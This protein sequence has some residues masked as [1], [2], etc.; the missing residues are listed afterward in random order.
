MNKKIFKVALLT[1]MIALLSASLVACGLFDAQKVITSADVDVVSGLDKVEDGVYKAQLGVETVLAVNWHNNRVS[2]A[3]VEWHV[4]SEGK[5]NKIE[6]ATD[7]TYRTTFTKSDLNKKFEYYVIVNGLITSG[8]ITV[9]VEVAKLSEPTISANLPMA[10]GII[11][12]N[13]VS[14]AQDVRLVANWNQ[15]DLADGTVVSVSWFVDGTK[16]EENSAQFTFGVGNVKDE[17]QVAIKVEITDGVQTTSSELTLV[18]VKKFDMAQSVAISADDSL[19]ELCDG[20]YYFKTTLD[21]DNK[22]KTFSTSLMPLSADQN[23]ACVWTLTDSTGK[24]TVLESQNRTQS[25]KLSYGKNVL[26]ATIQNV[27]SKQIIVYALDYDLGK[28]PAEM[29]AHME[30]KFLWLGNYY[31]TFISSQT[32]LN[33]F[34]GHAIS[35]HQKGVSFDAYLAIGD[36]CNNATFSEKL[37]KAVEEGGDESGNFSYSIRVSGSTGSVTFSDG[38]VFGVP[39]EAYEPKADSTQVQGHL[40][41]SEQTQKR[42]A[43]PIDSVT[44]SVKVANSNE[45]YRAVSCGYKPIFDSDEAG[46]ALKALY[47]EA[48]DVLATFLSDDMNDYQKVAAI[49]DWIINVVDYDYAVAS[50]G[51]TSSSQYNAFYLEGVFNDHRAVC[52]GKSKAFALLCGMENIKAVRVVGYANKDLQNLTEEEQKSCGHAWNKVLIDADGDGI[53]EW[54]VV[55]TTWGDLA[56]R[57][58]SPVTHE[59]LNYCYFLKT[60][61]DV[62]STHSARTQAPAATTVFNV[63]KNTFITI[64]LTTVDLKVDSVAE[65]NELLSYSKTN[66]NLALCV[67][68]SAAALKGGP[69]PISW[70]YVPLGNDQYVIY[71]RV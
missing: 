4:V 67:Q 25:I 68:M 48:R 32:D 53:R 38:T 57:D 14:G 10:D 50:L 29:K 20:T 47:D 56:V 62:A 15:S 36:W 8:K 21:G 11:Q 65:R 71:A 37:S 18:F 39:T 43:L 1:I 60:D 54:Y 3:R 16:Q 55:D 44:Q 49:Y 2:S 52:D 45:L 7:K 51:G 58:A 9:K 59:Y 17:R 41:F 31:D 6:G 63:Y 28:I 27:E 46:V 19:A 12:Q 40:R 5:D 30:D 69:S 70:G 34:M 61:A 13:L 42:T 64:G 22:T 23:A 35:K 24:T 26:K 66:G 33:A